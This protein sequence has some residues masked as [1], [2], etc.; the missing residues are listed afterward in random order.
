M[1]REQRREGEAPQEE[2][3]AKCRCWLRSLIVG[4]IEECCVF[5]VQKSVLLVAG[6]LARI[7]GGKCSTDCVKK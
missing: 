7:S 3:E 1:I 5:S 6:W 2:V 4:H